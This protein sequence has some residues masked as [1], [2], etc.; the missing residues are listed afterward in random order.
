L[1]QLDTIPDCVGPGAFTG[2]FGGATST[3]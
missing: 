2:A 3:Q 1:L